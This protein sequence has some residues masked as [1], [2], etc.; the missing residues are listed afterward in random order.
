MLVRLAQIGCVMVALGALAVFF[1]V[2]HFEQDLPDVR[3]LRANYKPAQVTRVLGRDGSLLAELFTERR[4]V[5]RFDE[6]PPHVRL[7]FLAAEDAG[8]YEHEGLNY[9][10]IA[11]AM[12]V[13]LRA[14]RT[15]QGGSTI[16]QQ[17][18]KN[19][20]LDPERTYSRKIKEALLARRLEQDLTKNE[21][22]E[23]YLNHIYLG[24]GRYGVEEAARYYF[25]KSIR[26]VTIAEAAL[27]A[28]L[29]A[30]PELYSPRHDL[31]RALARRGFVLE[32]MERK[33]FLKEQ[34]ATMAREAQV[35]LAPPIEAQSALA[36]EV[37][38]VARRTL[39]DVVGEGYSRGGYTVYTT[40]DPKMQALARK[41]VRENLQ[42]FDKRTKAQAP[43]KAPLTGKKAPKLKPE[44]KPFEGMPK[45]N[46]L[47]RSYVGVVTAAHDDAGI[48]DVQVGDVEGYIK[49]ADVDRFNPKHLPPSAFAEV[50]AYL[51]V[52][53]LIP[54]RIASA[55]KAASKTP[56]R[57]D[58]GAES[59]LVAIEPKSR[60]IVAL[61]GSY[62][63]V[64]G[65]LDRATQSKRQP[66]STF[67]PI[68]Y[69]Y[70]LASRKVTP[71]TVFELTPPPQAGKNINASAPSSADP[72]RLRE[73][74]AKSVNTVAQRVM[75]D[76]GPTNVVAWAQKM[77]IT[78][79]LGAD[80]S[81]ALGA[82][83]IS[84]LE[85]AG[86][87]ATFASGGM[88]EAP[89]IITKIV[90]PD[91]KEVPLPSRQPAQ[92]VMEESE[93]YLTTSLLTSVID[94]GT[95]ARA[96]ELGRPLA[97][98][99]GTTNQAKDTWFIGYSTDM[100][101]AVWVGFDEPR[102]LNGG[103]ESGASAAL[104]AWMAF[105][106]G[107][108][109][110]R[111]ATDFPRPTGLV[112][113]KIDPLSGLRAYEGQTDALDELFLAGTEPVEVAQPV[114]AGVEEPD[115]APLPPEETPEIAGHQPPPMP[116]PEQLEQPATVETALPPL[117]ALPP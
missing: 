68:L 74:V 8:F 97:G 34:E 20:L 57:L 103:K 96:K 113:V 83:E 87:Y 39:K 59:A 67:K 80:L 94:H 70:A 64:A 14:G 37:V 108:H 99:T 54:P 62:A 84:P 49:I 52:S 42:S 89:H 110:K 16:T 17:V 56:L 44:D 18:V 82:Y 60:D 26:D 19:I 24:G 50:G 111:P 11:R 72:L 81:L 100:V 117:P 1:F 43:F 58:M 53:F 33:G 61:I 51:R 5:V 15:R 92:R 21:I 55:D 30:G 109:D 45:P 105:M 4:T 91:G 116:Q 85:M 7:A 2:R 112:T 79:K 75:V 40:I 36:P 23:L 28:A 32:Q 38:E 65:A 12:V 69:S 115:A 95:G 10:G 46:E 104:P 102:P 106:K 27:L 98:K 76:A 71:A 48:L 6:I 3:G 107:A 22:L 114:D 77:G 86:A 88:Y 47:Y 63:A 90:G 29:P 78:A 13:N 9:F 73:A 66:G 31:Q 93:A 25:G 101:C 41:A 35:L